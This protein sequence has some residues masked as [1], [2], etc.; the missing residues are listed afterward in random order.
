MVLIDM[1]SLEIV[2]K[3]Y[4][5]IYMKRKGVQDSKYFRQ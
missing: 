1:N 2:Y 4:S 5:P 3:L